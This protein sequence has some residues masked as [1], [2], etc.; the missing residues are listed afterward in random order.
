ME[1]HSP[2]APGLRHR[3]AERPMPRIR[4]LGHVVLK[5]R[6]LTASVIFYRDV[7]GFQI[8]DRNER[9]MVFLRHG[10]DHHSLALVE[11]P[12]DRPLSAPDEVGLHHFAWEVTDITDVVRARDWLRTQGTPIV[13]EGRRGPGGNVGI[14]FK[15]P[16]GNQIEIYC[17]MV[18]I[19]WN[20]SSPPAETWQRT[21]SIDAI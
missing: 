21:T 11:V 19:G 18:Q 14:E 4:K 17:A 15:D 9:G 3:D 2:S 5:V 7:L 10:T 12:S 16:D 20:G 1:R 8:S 13:F 6:D